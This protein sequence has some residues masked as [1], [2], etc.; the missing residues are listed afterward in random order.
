MLEEVDLKK[1]EDLDPFQTDGFQSNCKVT[2]PVKIVY[3][4]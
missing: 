4:D 1:L 2:L 3:V